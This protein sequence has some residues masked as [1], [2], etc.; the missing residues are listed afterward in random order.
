M[1]VTVHHKQ[2][3]TLESF[4]PLVENEQYLDIAFMPIQ[5]TLKIFCNFFQFCHSMVKKHSFACFL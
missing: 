5:E 1:L 2:I 3:R 4:F